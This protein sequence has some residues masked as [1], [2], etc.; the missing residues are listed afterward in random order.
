[1][2]EIR[3]IY[4]DVVDSY[5]VSKYESGIVQLLINT[6]DKWVDYGPLQTGDDIPYINI[7]DTYILQVPELTHNTIF[8]T[9]VTETQNKDQISFYFLPY[10]LITDNKNMID[11]VIE[12]RKNLQ[13]ER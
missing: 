13:D 7:D 5:S 6:K 4:D 10:E 11:R 2:I 12:Q 1:M 3:K 8:K 9:V